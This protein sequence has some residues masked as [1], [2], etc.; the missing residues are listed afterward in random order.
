[1]LRPAKY[2]ISI[3]YLIKGMN[4][5]VLEG[6]KKLCKLLYF[7]DFGSFEKNG[8]SITGD[9]YLRL[10]MGPVPSHFD[11]V[12]SEMEGNSLQISEEKKN[13]NHE[14]KT[15]IYRVANEPNFTALTS[16]EK[17]ML[18]WVIEKYGKLTGKELED[19]SH[20]EAPWLAVK[21]TGEEIPYEL[22][23]YRGTSF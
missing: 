4:S 15:T 9:V 3:M 23:Y 13:P 11:S 6:K 8:D 19:I 17:E 10:P 14:N 20:N 18:D 2:K 5:E 16:E 1:M 12:I 7:A 22:S 21:N